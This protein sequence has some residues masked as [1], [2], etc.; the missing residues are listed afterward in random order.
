M[1]IDYLG[2]GPYADYTQ[3]GDMIRIGDLEIDCGAIQADSQII[4]DICDDG[5]GGL[6]I[7]TGDGKAYVASIIVPARQYMEQEATDDAGNPVLDDDGNP[8]IERVA[9]P[10]D[11]N[12]VSLKLWTKTEQKQEEEV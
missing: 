8:V 10:F 4:V 5:A 12:Q 2:T 3:P 7:G 9:L 6:A 1:Q 11:I